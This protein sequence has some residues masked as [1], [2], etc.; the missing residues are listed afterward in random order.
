VNQLG[1]DE[2]VAKLVNKL[3]H[4]IVAED[5][6]YCDLSRNLNE[7]YE[8]FWNRNMATLTTTYFRDIW[9]GTATVVGIIF[10]LLTFWN[11]FLRHFVK[12]PRSWS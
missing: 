3:G 6:C 10:L 12:M 1:S 9:R 8:S 11:I 4:Q 5:S 7:H 2:A